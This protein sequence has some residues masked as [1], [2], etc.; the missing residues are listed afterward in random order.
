LQRRLASSPEAIY[1][2]LRRRKARLEHRL[3]E[4]QQRD[5]ERVD[6]GLGQAGRGQAPSL[7]YTGLAGRSSVE[8]ERA[9]RSP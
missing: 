7:L 3:Q 9:W 1:Q 4:E 2:S 6:T 8:E 5:V